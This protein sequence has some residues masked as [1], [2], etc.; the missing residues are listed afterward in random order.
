M[1]KKILV[2]VTTLKEISGTASQTLLV[3]EENVPRLSAHYRAVRV[4]K[5]NL[6]Q[7]GTNFLGDNK[8]N[9]C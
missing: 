3:V 2:K 6:D 7:S 8:V 5:K 4:V 1:E 9:F